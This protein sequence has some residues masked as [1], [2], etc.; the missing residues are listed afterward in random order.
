MKKTRRN[1]T[2]PTNIRLISTRITVA[3]KNI[4]TPL[5]LLWYL[6]TSCD[7]VPEYS[8]IRKLDTCCENEM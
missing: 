1:F 7:Q 5:Y 6:H 4:G 8:K 3:I 2:F